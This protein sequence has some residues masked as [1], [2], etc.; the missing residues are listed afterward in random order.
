MQPTLSLVVS[1]VLAIISKWWWLLCYVQLV[2]STIQLT[3]IAPYFLPIHSD[4]A[5]IRTHKRIISYIL[6]YGSR[7]RSFSEYCKKI[8]TTS[9][10][11]QEDAIVD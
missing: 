3:Y 10:T 11:I 6:I 2:I 9:C 4:P 7:L 5:I 1:R 8:L